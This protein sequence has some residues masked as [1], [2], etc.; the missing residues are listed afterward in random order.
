MVLYERIFQISH[1][2]SMGLKHF[3]PVNS[4]Y[5]VLP[6]W[7]V[8]WCGSAFSSQV[9]ENVAFFQINFYTDKRMYV[10]Q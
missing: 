9:S 4:T 2:E 10:I 6:G 7:V 8:A 1:F 3:L 5:F